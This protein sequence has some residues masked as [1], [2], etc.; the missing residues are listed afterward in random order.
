M[1]SI[2]PEV[3]YNRL[4]NRIIEHLDLVASAEKQLAYQQAAPIAHVS[5]ELF[6]AWGDWVADEAT[7]DEFQ[8]PIF[9]LEEQQAVRVFNAQV[10]A[11]ARKTPQELPYITSFIDTPAWRELSASASAAL[12]VFMV[13]GFGPED[14]GA[15]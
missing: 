13:R 1:D 7:I 14:G 2:A 5:D 4:R 6:N 3:L 11:V 12:A 9:S 15:I 8:A 10:D